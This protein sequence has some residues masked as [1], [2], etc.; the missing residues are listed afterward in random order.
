MKKTINMVFENCT[1]DGNTLIECSKNDDYS[2]EHDIMGIFQQLN[3]EDG[4][5]ITIKKT[6]K[7]GEIHVNDSE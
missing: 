5:T 1:V 4:L 6:T 7:S 2:L 3:G